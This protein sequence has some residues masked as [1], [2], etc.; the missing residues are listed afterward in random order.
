MTTTLKILNPDATL[1]NTCY[2]CG[3]LD[4]AR[5][6][7][8]KCMVAGS[9]P[10]VKV[11]AKKED[12]PMKSEQLEP[13][14][15]RARALKSW[16]K[17]EAAKRGIVLPPTV[18]DLATVPGG[19]VSISLDSAFEGTDGPLTVDQFKQNLDK[20]FEAFEGVEGLKVRKADS[21]E[22]CYGYYLVLYKDVLETT[23]A[24]KARIRKNLAVSVKRK[25]VK[26]QIEQRERATYLR[27]H[28][29]YG[30]KS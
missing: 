18:L 12:T 29:K 22:G 10:A 28:E 4:P 14:V 11:S 16:A 13:E 7:Y 21:L 5:N 6:T 26:E 8:F 20:L 30:D 19:E 17:M 2:M 15:K 23:V 3:Y 9:C 24:Y 1:K 25:D 27:L